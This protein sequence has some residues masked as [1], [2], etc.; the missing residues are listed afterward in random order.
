VGGKESEDE[1]DAEVEA[2]LC[3]ISIPLTNFPFNF[4]KKQDCVEASS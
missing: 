1:E 4:Q 2:I 3:E